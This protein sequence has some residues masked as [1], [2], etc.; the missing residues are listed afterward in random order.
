M[1]LETATQANATEG[2][3]KWYT[4]GLLWFVF[5]FNYADRQAIFSIFPLIKTE[6]Q[7]TDVQLGVLGACFM[8]VYALCGPFTGWLTD[9]ISRKTLILGSLIFWSAVTGA[10][11]LTHTFHE[12]VWCRAL[13]G[14]GEAFYFPAAMAMISDYHGP[15]TRSRALSL[16]QSAVYAGSIAGGSISAVV[17]Q[18]SG[19]RSSFVVFGL[20]GILLGL[21][22]MFLLREPSRGLSEPE[23]LRREER[24]ERGNVGKVLR[25]IFGDRIVLLLMAVFMGANFVAVVFLTWLPT[26][27]Y[28]KFHMSLSMAGINSTIYLQIASLLGV[29]CG[30]VLA[31]RFSRK[32]RGGRLLAQS[33][34]LLLGA[35]FLFLTGWTQLVPVLVVAMIGFGYFKGIYDANIIA[36]LYDI[37]PVA[38]RGTAAG[39]TNSLG[40]LGGGMAPVIIAIASAHF[41]MSACMSATAGIYLVIGIT[42]FA[43]SRRLRNR[44]VASTSITAGV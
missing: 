3:W 26:F 15:A 8:W 44:T 34:G 13:G 23:S 6:L 11:A 5:L 43:A 10:T 41:G 35:P 7:L 2:R 16:H 37:I 21:V 42:M 40:W 36:S 17:G 22:L 31:D 39:I 27:L 1:S 4:I 25:E 32:T 20:G 30:G 12:M 29:L 28:Q 9:R 33:L 38:S 24:K 18:H 19:W 14:L